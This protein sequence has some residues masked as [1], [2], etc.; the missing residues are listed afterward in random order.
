MVVYKG[1]EYRVKSVSTF[2]NGVNYL[3]ETLVLEEGIEDID[4]FS[5]NEFRKL[6]SVTLPSSLRHVGRNAFRNNSGMQFHLASN[7]S[8]AMLRSGK[9]FNPAP[10]ASGA[11]D[12]SNSRLM[13][14]AAC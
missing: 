1:V 12:S 2:L 4:K 11:T 6:V 5:F 13:A 14:Q 7:I 3:A 9:D 8:E 10:A